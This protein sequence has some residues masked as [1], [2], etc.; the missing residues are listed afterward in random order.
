MLAAQTAVM[1]IDT[2][3]EEPV[4]ADRAIAALHIRTVDALAGYVKMVEKAEAD[5]RSV[6]DQFRALHALHAGRLERM[7]AAH[8]QTADVDGSFMATVNKT[9][10][11]L[12]A[13]FDEID[14]DVMNSVR[15]GENHVL[16]AFDLALET[17][18]PS[19]QVQLREMRDELTDL[20]RKTS[21]LN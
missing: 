9:V 19:D 12:R 10:I 18:Q 2:P 14:A 4:A 5:F 3:E 20:L 16:A 7:L 6:A 21:H 13:F 8:G 15:N 1:M 17:A 11:A